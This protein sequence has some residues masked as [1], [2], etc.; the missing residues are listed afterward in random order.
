MFGQVTGLCFGR[1]PPLTYTCKRSLICRSD[2]IP[3]TTSFHRNPV[4]SPRSP[5]AMRWINEIS[6]CPSRRDAVD[7]QLFGGTVRCIGA[8]DYLWLKSIYDKKSIQ[9]I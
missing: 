2:S 7:L 1:S 4:P 8:S 3:L 5:L 9:P 6:A